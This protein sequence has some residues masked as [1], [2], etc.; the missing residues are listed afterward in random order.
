MGKLDCS[1]SDG[2][3][4]SGE[5]EC[6]SAAVKL[7][8]HISEPVQTGSYFPKGCSKYWTGYVYWNE[9]RSGRANSYFSPIC[10]VEGNNFPKVNLKLYTVLFNKITN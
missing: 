4:I 9:H 6:K 7:G 3:D 1:E 5:T 8:F 2:E 10:K